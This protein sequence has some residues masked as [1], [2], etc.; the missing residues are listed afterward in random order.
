MTELKIAYLISSNVQASLTMI[1]DTINELGYEV[2]LF[3]LNDKIVYTDQGDYDIIILEPDMSNWEWLDILLYRRSRNP[4]TPVILF[5]INAALNKGFSPMS[6]DTSVFLVNDLDMLKKNFHLILGI[7]NLSKKQI[8]FVDD[9]VNVLRSYERSLRKT[10]WRILTVNGA[11]KALEILSKE[12]IDLI[13]TDI[14]MPGIHGFELIRKIREKHGSL[15]II[16]CSGYHGMEEDIEIQF[17]DVAAF[18]EKP[19]NMEA[20]GKKIKAVLG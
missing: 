3:R 17:H 13:V 14:K 15:P 12:K 11:E 20:L 16:V 6:M 18:L 8:L 4:E 7:L 9:D 1:K 2:S 10:P 5:S 19:V